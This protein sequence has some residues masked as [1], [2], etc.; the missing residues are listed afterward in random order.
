MAVAVSLALLALPARVAL[1]D[2]APAPAGPGFL[3]VRPSFWGSYGLRLHRDGAD[4]AIGFL[5]R[6]L[7]D[8]VRGS[9]AAERHARHA[10]IWAGIQLGA[11]ATAAGLMVADLLTYPGDHGGDLSGWPDFVPG[12]DAP[13]W[14]YLG[15]GWFIA[16]ALGVVARYQAYEEIAIAVNAYN[17]DG[18]QRCAQA[19]A[20]AAPARGIA[21][22]RW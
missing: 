1:A 8:A 6:D 17:R 11:T 19:P 18:T 7:D 16:L 5:A 22:L 21:I 4:V 10:Q 9:P 15:M 13:R 20:P 12:A 14:S 3:E 2:P